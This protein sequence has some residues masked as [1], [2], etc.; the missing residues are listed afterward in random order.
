MVQVVYI[1]RHGDA[2]SVG[3]PGVS[4][5]VERHLSEEGRMKLKL[6]AVGFKQLGETIQRCFASPLIRAYQTA[7]IMSQPFSLPQG[8]EKVEALGNMPNLK[9]IQQLL[10]N[11]AE[12]QILL[13][14][15]EPFVAQLVAALTG[16]PKTMG[17]MFDKGSMAKIELHR[18]HPEP[19]GVLHWFLSPEHLQTFAQI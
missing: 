15:H 4:H 18:L 13:L 14:S 8:I 11:T 7:E 5:D 3:H 16:A 6:Q 1:M 9:T 2:V 17:L 19:I 10:Q 12:S